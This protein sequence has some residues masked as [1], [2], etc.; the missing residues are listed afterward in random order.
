MRIAMTLFLLA[1]PVSAI[2]AGAEPADGRPAVP[3]VRPGDPTVDG[4]K[5]E[6]YENA[7]RYVRVAS[8]GSRTEIGLWTDRLEIVEEDGERLLERRQRI[9]GPAGDRVFTNRARRADLTPR[10]FEVATVDGTMLQRVD[11]EPDA[12]RIRIGG[13]DAPIDQP[14]DEPVFDWMWYGI[15]AAAFPLEAGY[16]ADYPGLTATLGPTVRKLRVTG[17]E[18][19]ADG[20]GRE[21]PCWRVEMDDGLVFWVADA[22]PYILRAEMHHV[23]G[24]ATFWEIEP[25]DGAPAPSVDGEG[26]SDTASNANAT[27]PATST[28]GTTGSG[29]DGDAVAPRAAAPSAE[30]GANRDGVAGYST[31]VELRAYGT[32]PGQAGPFLEHF[33]RHYLESQEAYEMRIWGQFRDLDVEDRFVWIRGYRSMAERREGVFGFYTSDV[34]RETS[35]PLAGMLASSH[36]VHFLEALAPD[37]G[38]DEDAA[39]DEDA[40]VAGVVVAE[41]FAVDGGRFDDVADRLHATRLPAFAAHGARSLGLFRS[42]DEANDIPQMP[43]IEDEP[44]VVWFSSHP[45]RAAYDRARKAARD[46]AGGGVGDPFET[47]VLAPGARS[48]LSH[49]GAPPSE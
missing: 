10:Y 14:L 2:G 46:A 41:L 15:L 20:E 42:S 27:T 49:R 8:D 32:Y 35:P 43:F 7:W 22:P 31:F 13:Q 36:H 48:R 19:V 3:I 5:L 18:P 12:I 39:R 44:A 11:F 47:F 25:T 37:E 33:E 40:A 21:R 6:P 9:P 24:S 1:A 30:R 34:W 29:E 26:S 23:G 4:G 38:F 45:S 16:E 28:A 17:R